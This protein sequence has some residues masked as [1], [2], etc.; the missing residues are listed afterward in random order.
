MEARQL[1]VGAKLVVSTPDGEE[2]DEIIRVLVDDVVAG[3]WVVETVRNG[4]VIVMRG[5]NGSYQLSD[6]S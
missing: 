3:V 6:F 4:R 5:R 2:E 1:S